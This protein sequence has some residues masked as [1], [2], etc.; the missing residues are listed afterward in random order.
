[1]RS[2]TFWPVMGLVRR[3]VLLAGLVAAAAAVMAGPM[4]VRAADD[5]QTPFRVSTDTANP[6]TTTQSGEVATTRDAGLVGEYGG[7][8]RFAGYAIDGSQMLILDTA[9]GMARAQGTF[10]ATS[11]NGGSSITVTY[12]GQV[13]FAGGTATGNF[14]AGN[15]TGDDAGYRASGTLKGDVVPPATLVGVNIGLC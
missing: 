15:G 1:M 9:T 8:G 6:G 7:N 11:P 2:A 13:D 14:V 10:V 4:P 3:G 12:T 5:C